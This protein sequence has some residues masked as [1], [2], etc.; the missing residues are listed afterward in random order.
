M[1]IIFKVTRAKAFDLV[2]HK[3]CMMIEVVSID[4]LRMSI[5]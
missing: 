5:K 4:G 2:A 3:W 1:W